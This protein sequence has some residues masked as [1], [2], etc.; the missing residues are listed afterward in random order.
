MTKR[1]IK[2]EK[3][4]GRPGELG[5][6]SKK[7]ELCLSPQIMSSAIWRRTST[8]TSLSVLNETE[9][10]SGVY[11]RF[12]S[13]NFFRGRKIKL[14]I[15]GGTGTVYAPVANPPHTALGDH[16]GCNS[17]GDYITPGTISNPGI[18]KPRVSIPVRCLAT[19]RTVKPAMAAFEYFSY[20][21]TIQPN[22]EIKA[23][24]LGGFQ[25]SIETGESYQISELFSEVEADVLKVAGKEASSTR[26]TSELLKAVSSQN[27][28]GR[29]KAWLALLGNA[30]GFHS[31]S[32]NQVKPA[33]EF[34][35]SLLP[36][37]SEL[38]SGQ[39]RYVS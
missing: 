4:R 30:L 32:K 7:L 39:K 31:D 10:K 18:Q 26:T 23:I 9:V 3:G 36:H 1:R 15:A 37:L 33:E 27:Q 14:S 5:Y 2:R 17:F 12:S 28:E 20:P 38:S 13:E 29:A 35:K 11:F 25:Y 22:H 16:E 34:C 8:M 24:S 21:A 6:D 19:V